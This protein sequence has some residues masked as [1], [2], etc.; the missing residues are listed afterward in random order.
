MTVECST[1]KTKFPEEF[2]NNLN[3]IKAADTDS[4]N[5]ICLN[6]LQN[7]EGKNRICSNIFRDNKKILLEFQIKIFTD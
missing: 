1:P 7:F 5:I 2:M 6:G 4:N 3:Y